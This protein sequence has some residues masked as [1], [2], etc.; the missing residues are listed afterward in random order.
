MVLSRIV[1][2]DDGVAPLELVDL[3][4]PEPRA[5]EVLVG[6]VESR[7]HLARTASLRS[8]VHPTGVLVFHRSKDPVEIQPSRHRLL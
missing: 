3:P 6:G 4:K 8:R 1:A 5:G 2:L 7:G